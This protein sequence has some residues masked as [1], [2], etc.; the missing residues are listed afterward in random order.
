MTEINEKAID[1]QGWLS[2]AF[3]LTLDVKARG[4]S[5]IR[6]TLL[7]MM[8]EK[9]PKHLNNNTEKQQCRSLK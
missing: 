1:F 3:S 4:K 5:R 6:P 9:M 8:E 2:G 7:D